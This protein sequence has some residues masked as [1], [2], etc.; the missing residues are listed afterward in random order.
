[1]DI[2]GP[3]STTIL[4]AR[5]SSMSHRPEAYSSAH[6][7]D[8]DYVPTHQSSDTSA[9]LGSHLISDDA[10]VAMLAAT[11]TKK[12]RPLPLDEPTQLRHHII[13]DWQTNYVQN[14]AKCR[15]ERLSRQETILAKTNAEIWTWECGLGNIGKATSTSNA[16]VPTHHLFSEFAGSLLRDRLT[17]FKSDVLTSR[18]RKRG[19]ESDEMDEIQSENGRRVRQR[20]EVS[21]M[22]GTGGYINEGIEEQGFTL[23]EDEYQVSHII[24]TVI[25]I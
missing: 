12:A 15:K 3:G 2:T 1:M 17:G 6:A 16:V 10:A 24:R 13:K 8:R 22:N 25:G 9:R 11:T 5:E 23:E 4:D 20:S 21:L 7:D 18:R 19:V 14:M